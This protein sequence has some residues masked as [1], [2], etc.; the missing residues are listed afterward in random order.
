MNIQMLATT[1]VNVCYTVV[2]VAVVVVAN[3]KIYLYIAT[4]P[5]L[6]ITINVPCMVTT[7]K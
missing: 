7:Y 1:L 5:Q 6:A 4:L 2:V 3:E